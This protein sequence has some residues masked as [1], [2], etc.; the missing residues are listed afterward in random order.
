[1]KSHEKF[2]KNAQAMLPYD[3][4][5]TSDWRNSVRECPHS[6]C[7]L[8]WVKVAGCDGDTTCGAR[9]FSE[10]EKSE[11]KGEAILGWAW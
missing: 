7:K 1:M 2:K 4:S 8:V 10:S 11:T 5:D 3:I 6:D 9:G